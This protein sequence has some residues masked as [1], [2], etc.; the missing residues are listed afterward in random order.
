MATLNG[1]LDE[2]SPDDTTTVRRV[3]ST[4]DQIVQSATLTSATPQTD[5]ERTWRYYRPVVEL[6][7]KTVQREGWDFLIELLDSYNPDDQFGVP[8][9][10]HA[11]VNV[12]G[13]FV[14]RTRIRDGI[15]TVPTAAL[16]YLR[17]FSSVKDHPLA[18]KESQAYG[19]AIGHPDNPATEYLRTSVENKPWWT[20]AALE[21]ALYADQRA[22]ANLLET[23]VQDES[24]N[25]SVQLSPES[26]VSKERFLFECLVGPDTDEY[27]PNVPRF[28]SQWP[29]IIE[30]FQWSKP[31]ELDLR[32]LIRGTEVVHD[33][34]DDWTFQDLSFNSSTGP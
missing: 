22:A 7:D 15:E 32:S 13:R 28:W 30:E 10:S 27:H 21:H 4:Y 34:P 18:R 5:R 12:V 29:E 11:L 1:L 3:L 6:L 9:C 25:F 26:T 19:W 8:P 23:L 14:V 20:L 31:V 33:L 17:A 24:I 16:R 2:A